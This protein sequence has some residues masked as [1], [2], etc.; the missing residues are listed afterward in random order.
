MKNKEEKLTIGTA[1][2]ALID[3]GDGSRC[4][5]CLL[6]VELIEC[7]Q[8]INEHLERHVE[9]D[10]E[11]LANERK[12]IADE[13]ELLMDKDIAEELQATFAIATGKDHCV[14]CGASPLS[15]RKKVLAIIN[16]EE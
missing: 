16:K 6:P 9:T 7:E 1:Y 14:V 3:Y 13:V 4:A 11:A 2:Y 5:W 8:A 15:Q 10:G 12:R